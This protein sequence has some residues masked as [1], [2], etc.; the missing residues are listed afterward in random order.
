MTDIETMRTDVTPALAGTACD[1]LTAMAQG[2]VRGI[3]TLFNE[4]EWAGA[5]VPAFLEFKAGTAGMDGE[6][7]EALLG[8]FEDYFNHY[9]TVGEFQRLFATRGYK[10]DF[11]QLEECF[12]SACRD[13]NVRLARLNFSALLFKALR[14]IQALVEKREMLHRF[15]VRWLSDEVLLQFDTSIIDGYANK[16]IYHTFW[17]DALIAALE[18]LPMEPV[19]K[20]LDY[21]STSGAGSGVE[22]YF[23]HRHAFIMKY[24]GRNGKKL[25]DRGF[26]EE[27]LDEFINFSC[28]HG[29]CRSFDGNKPRQKLVRWITA[30]EDPLCRLVVEEK[31]LGVAVDAA[32]PLNCRYHGLEALKGLKEKRPATQGRLLERAENPAE[33]DAL[34]SKCLDALGPAAGAE[35]STVERVLGLARD[36]SGHW[37]LRCSAAAVLGTWGAGKEAVP[38][39]LELTA[40]AAGEPETLGR[41]AE[42]LGRLG[43]VK[44]AREIF[45]SLLKA[46]GQPPDAQVA[47]A[48]SL[49]NL[50]QENKAAGILW[51]LLKQDTLGLQ[52]MKE[53]TAAL[54]R[55]GQGKKTAQLLLKYIGN[56]GLDLSRRCLY[57]EA[58]GE[59]GIEDKNVAIRLLRVAEDDQAEMGLRHKCVEAVGK[60]KITDKSLAYRLLRVFEGREDDE[61]SSQCAVAA[62]RL[63]L[64]DKPL[65]EQFL[66]WSKH[67]GM[68]IQLRR[69]CIAAAGHLGFRYKAVDLL[70]EMYLQQ[71]DKYSDTARQIFDALWELTAH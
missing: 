44:K 55:W 68:T 15:S 11:F 63:R 24:L 25:G 62:A 43:E 31:L 7:E 40:T 37:G 39:M 36:A 22:T 8:I 20:I 21:L 2:S 18:G 46:G 6:A 5:L 60:L 14:G 38:V 57:A 58:L 19:R 26:I 12:L 30:L 52:P 23:F 45:L 71:Q 16:F 29:S 59:S 35:R 10:V 69:D 66:N 54:C 4:E 48:V 9:A 51:D 64:K 47:R 1:L 3:R 32:K 13:K 53:G 28:C 65:A 17:Q 34:R 70:T 33:E 67:K 27:R 56:P 50:G 41:C 42:I 61:L 49:G